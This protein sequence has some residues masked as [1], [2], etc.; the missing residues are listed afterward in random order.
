MFH[1][2]NLVK[3]LKAQTSIK[4]LKTI[5]VYWRALVEVKTI[6]DLRASLKESVQSYLRHWI[7]EPSFWI[8]SK[9]P[10]QVD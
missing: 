9:I 3:I 4:E 6:L 1:S 7:D 5:Q 10:P 8:R 2:I